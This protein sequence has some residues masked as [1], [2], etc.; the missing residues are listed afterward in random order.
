MTSNFWTRTRKGDGPGGDTAGD[1]DLHAS[2]S[3]YASMT[4]EVPEP[5]ARALADW[6]DCIDP[7]D[8]ANLVVEP[9]RSSRAVSFQ[10][11][12]P[13]NCWVVRDRKVRVS[14]PKPLDVRSQQ[15][16]AKD[17]VLVLTGATRNVR[18]LLRGEGGVLYLG[19]I[20]RSFNGEVAVGAGSRVIVGDDASATS[21]RCFA[22]DSDV[23]I[24]RDCMLAGD[25]TLNSA[26]QHG[27]VDL[28]PDGP[29]MRSYV[30]R[31]LELGT[32]VWLGY[33]T[34][35]QGAV[36]IGSGSIIGGASVV[37]KDIPTNV[38]AAGNPA[39]VKRQNV[40]WCR[41]SEEIDARSLSYA[42]DAI[43][44]IFD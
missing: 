16:P 44:T 12:P 36:Q 40:T 29:V 37:V 43:R 2:G 39:E 18:V 21:V 15:M 42:E 11:K 20:G 27:I 35:V 7:I 31:R 26:R 6:P 9:I 33:R 22:V 25:V 10:G 3:T 13:E 1:G 5:V 4:G 24:G 30:R 8:P 38:L 14:Q 28:T 19:R 17:S 34:L 41:S 32:H 23:V